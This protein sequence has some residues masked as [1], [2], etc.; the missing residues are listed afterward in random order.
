MNMSLGLLIV[1]LAGILQG[2][3]FLPMTYTK[4]W[5]WSHKWF[6]FS[7]LAMLL[8]NWVIAFLSIHDIF[9][10]ISRIPLTSLL[11]V[12]F[13]GLC[14]GA[15]AILFGKAM[16]LLGMALGYPLIMGINAAAGTIIPALVFS[17]EI[18]IRYKGIVIIIGALFSIGGIV[19]CA[20]AS[21]LKNEGQQK[22]KFSRKGMI[23][24]IISGFTSCLPNIGAAFSN[25]ITTLALDSGVNNV[26]AG[27]VVWSLFFTMGAVVN[28]GHCMYLMILNKNSGELNN[29][30]RFLNWVL[31]LAMSLMWIGSFYAYGIGSFLLGDLGLIMGWPLLVSL[32]IIIGNL[33]GL[34]RGE[35][36]EA[37]RLSRIELNRGI[38]FLIISI[39]L[40]ATSNL[41]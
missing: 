9:A 5:E 4:K 26:M 30:H 1:G 7:L 21:A 37:S 18:F 41:F 3:F 32:S 20:K 27:N 36:Q 10:I 40:I 6:A 24:A 2:T 28:V 29:S 33:W 39:I 11:T 31:I 19:L 14:W 35:W 25:D 13:F 34:F 17:P 23:L 22:S 15:G 16:D 12:L 8:L 38:Y